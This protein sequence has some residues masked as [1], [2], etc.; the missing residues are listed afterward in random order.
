MDK[1]CKI[2]IPK[3]PDPFGLIGR[4]AY[5]DITVP[6][7]IESL[8]KCRPSFPESGSG[9]RALTSNYGYIMSTISQYNG[10]PE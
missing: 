1:M 2:R 8:A 7:R 9:S 4:A 6:L 3:Q 5:L 10:C